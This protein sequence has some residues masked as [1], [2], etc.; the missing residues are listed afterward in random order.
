MPFP[1][2]IQIIRDELQN[3]AELRKMSPQKQ[4]LFSVDLALIGLSVRWVK[5]VDAVGSSRGLRR[6]DAPTS[7]G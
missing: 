4:N 3:H 2:V 7:T 6:H 5:L 1:T